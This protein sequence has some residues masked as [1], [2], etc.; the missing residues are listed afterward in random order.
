MLFTRKFVD[1]KITMWVVVVSS[2]IC[3]EFVVSAAAVDFGGTR[4][5]N[6]QSGVGTVNANLL[7]RIG[8]PGSPT[9]FLRSC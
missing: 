3:T 7:K 1:K 5:H 4:V 6:Y 2:L 9:R 8:G